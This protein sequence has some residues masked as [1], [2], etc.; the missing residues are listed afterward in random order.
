MA[1]TVH[2]ASAVSQIGVAQGVSSLEINGHKLDDR[3]D[4]SSDD[5]RAKSGFQNPLH[6]FVVPVLPV[7]KNY[8]WGMHCTEALVANIYARSTGSALD[9]SQPYAELWIGTHSSASCKVRTPSS[10]EYENFRSFI[11][12]QVIVVDADKVAH[13]ERLHNAGLPFLL[14][15][16]SVAKPLSIQAHPDLALAAKLH[17]EVPDMYK[18]ANHKPEMAV[19][20]TPFEALCGFRPCESIVNDIARVPEFAIAVDRTAADSFVRSVKSRQSSVASLK[21]LFSSLMKRDLVHVSKIIESLVTRL[22]KM[23][24]SSLSSRDRLLLRLNSEFPGDVG[25]FSAYLLAYVRLEPGDSIFID[26][27]EPHAY[28]SGQCVEIM[29]CSDNVVRAGLT[30]KPKDVET[31]VEMLTY[32]DSPVK[33]SSGTK[34][35]DYSWMYRPPV[36][37]FMLVRHCIP[38]GINYQ[39]QKTAAPSI[40]LV[41][42]GNGSI[43]PKSNDPAFKGES[44]AMLLLSAGTIMY[45]HPGISYEVSSIENPAFISK[46]NGSTL[47]DLLFFRAGTNE[48]AIPSAST[49]AF[50]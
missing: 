6:P 29:A 19:A 4:V 27:N 47:P 18:D 45:L 14:K 24:E 43:R 36:Q 41:L 15:L 20:I 25:C 40:I 49:C 12:R 32:K 13:Y 28:L 23:D 44:N 21:S 42:A 50:M 5:E 22:G 46:M 16:L 31:L 39:L 34:L 9:I 33:V 38:S 17:G 37:E 30:P 7:V 1:T 2:E 10:T 8:A 48:S 26:A 11:Q 3:Q 35:D